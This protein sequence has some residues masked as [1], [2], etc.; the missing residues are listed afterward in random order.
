MK[1]LR[2]LPL[3]LTF[4]LT[5]ACG[6]S[7]NIDLP[8]F[9]GKSESDADESGSDWETDG[10]EAS[11]GIDLPGVTDSDG[12]G[13]GPTNGASDPCELAA[14]G[15]AGGA[16]ATDASATSNQD[17]SDGAQLVDPCVEE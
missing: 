10:G 1:S 16:P 12:D 6:L 7:P 15:G 11:G 17:A 3:L 4:P 14:A 5:A 9:G 8:S 13:S 2:V